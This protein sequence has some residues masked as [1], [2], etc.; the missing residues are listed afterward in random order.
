MPIANDE[1]SEDEVQRKIGETARQIGGKLGRVGIE[2]ELEL[3][4]V[5][6]V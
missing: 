3:F 4:P 6:F 2:P 5:C 1:L